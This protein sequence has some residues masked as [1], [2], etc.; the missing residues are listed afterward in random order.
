FARALDD[1]AVDR[2]GGAALANDA[3]TVLKLHGHAGAAL[4]GADEARALRLVL[5]DPAQGAQDGALAGI[6]RPRDDGQ[7]GRG[8]K[9]RV[10]VA[11]V[12]LDGEPYDPLHGATRSPCSCCWVMTSN[13]N[14]FASSRTSCSAPSSPASRSS[15]ASTSSPGRRPAWRTASTK[16]R[17]RACRSSASGSYRAP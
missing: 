14:C 12:V 17:S 7:T 3:R 10:G 1:V 11:L 16:A 9:D 13:S 8:L 2:A 15:S 5:V 4:P 6:R